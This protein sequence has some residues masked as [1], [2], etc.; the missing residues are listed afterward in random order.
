MSVTL[1]LSNTAL[2]A[3]AV[4]V[5]SLSATSTVH[6]FSTFH[7]GFLYCVASVT[8]SSGNLAFASVSPSFT[9]YVLPNNASSAIPVPFATVTLWNPSGSGFLSL[10]S[11]SSPLLMNFATRTCPSATFSAGALSQCQNT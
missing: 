6:G 8:F 5:K 2:T 7:A 9:A 4:N 1:S 3:F 10:G 11:I